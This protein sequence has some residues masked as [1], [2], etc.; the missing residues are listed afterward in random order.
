MTEKL[1]AIFMDQMGGKVDIF[2]RGGAE[3]CENCKDGNKF[4]WHDVVSRN[5]E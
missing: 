4:N 3:N 2:S 1:R 5:A